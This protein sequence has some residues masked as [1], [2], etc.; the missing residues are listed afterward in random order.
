MVKKSTFLEKCLNCD[1]EFHDQSKAV[2]CPECGQKNTDRNV[3]ISTLVMDFLGDYFTFDSKLFRSLWQLFTAPGYLTSAFNEGK[4]VRYIPPLRMYLFISF[5]FFL[6]AK[7]T[8]SSWDDNMTLLGVEDVKIVSDSE[9]II[10]EFSWISVEDSMLLKYY[11][12]DSFAELRPHHKNDFLTNYDADRMI[13]AMKPK[14]KIEE[15]I[16]R[17]F[18]G[19]LKTTRGNLINVVLGN[20]PVALFIAMPFFAFLLFLFF[21][22][23][24]SH[25]IEHLIHAL[26]FHTWIFVLL[27]LATLSSASIG[28]VFVLLFLIGYQW[29]SAVQVYNQ[30]FIFTAIKLSAVNFIYLLFLSIIASIVFLVSLIQI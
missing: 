24:A 10:D 12:L 17:E 9:S 3:K 7:L 15:L 21:R 16:F 14:N 2:Y 25:Y 26:H 27:I 1:Y 4:R 13:A 19:I 29:I 23:S 28:L 20:L 18:D 8:F 30:R 22:R 5:I 6:L 11:D